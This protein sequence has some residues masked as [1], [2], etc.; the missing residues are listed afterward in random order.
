M[1]LILRFLVAAVGVSLF[2]T[3][4]APAMAQQAPDVRGYTALMLL[5][6]AD[7]ETVRHN[8]GDVDVA[9]VVEPPLDVA[10]GHRLAV[11]LDGRELPLRSIG[12]RFVVPGIDRGEHRL[13]VV[14]AAS[15]GTRLIQSD[16]RTVHVWRASR[17]F[18]N[19]QP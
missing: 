18:P 15:D 6:P 11:V 4:V 12:T 16:E 10:A 9:V 5:A 14:V 7:G 13:R 17:R 19:R 1:T 3:W 2:L 8:A